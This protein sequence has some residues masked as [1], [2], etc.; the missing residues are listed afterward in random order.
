MPNYRF[1]KHPPKV[2]YRTL[3]FKN[4]LTPKIAAPPAAYNVLTASVY[5]ETEDDRPN[6]VVPHGRQRHPGRL[7]H[8]RA[9]P[10]R[11]GVSRDARQA[12]NHGASSRGQG[13][14]APDRRR[15]LRPERTRR[16]ELLAAEP[17]SPATRSST[18]SASI[19]RITP[20]SSWQ[21][22]SLAA[23]TWVSRCSKTAC[24]NSTQH[25]PWTPGPLTNDGHA[26]YAVG[27]RPERRDRADLGQHAAGHLGVVG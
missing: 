18:T 13:V 7:H 26:V 1:G 5:P 25:Q 23:C 6:Q 20:M 11:D 22:S 19:R 16:A 2:D 10:R 21:S 8:R 14:H 24:R 27:V 17:R 12:K 3:R 15:G 4:Y 9:G